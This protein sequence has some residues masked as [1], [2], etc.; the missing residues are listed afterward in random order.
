MNLCRIN[1]THQ[2]VWAMDTQTTIDLIKFLQERATQIRYIPNEGLE[3][4]HDKI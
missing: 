1:D 4:E 2:F 3:V